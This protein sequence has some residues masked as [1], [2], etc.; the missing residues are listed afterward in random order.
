MKKIYIV[1][2]IFSFACTNEKNICGRTYYYYGLFNEERV[3]ND[4]LIYE[5][6]LGNMF[7]GFIGIELFF[8]PTVK[9]IGYE[10]FEPICY[11]KKYDYK[12]RDTLI[13]TTIYK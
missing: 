7:F 11:K 10:L 4:S 3:K 2:L 6:S 5:P 13:I 12:N 1:L 8:I 9:V